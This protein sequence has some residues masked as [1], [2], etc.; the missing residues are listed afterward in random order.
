VTA[1]DAP[2]SWRAIDFLSDVH[3]HADMPRTFDAWSRHLRATDADAVFILGDLFEVWV[4]DDARAEG[5]EARCVE[6]LTQAAAHRTLAFMPGNRDFLVGD[7]LLREARVQRL[8]DPTRLDAFGQRLLLTHGDALCLADDEYQRFRA[9]VRG[10]DWQRD[11]LAKPLAERRALA[12]AMRDASA[13]RQ[14]GMGA[15]EAPNWADV[16]EAAALAWLQAADAPTLLH[17]HTHRPA[18][19]MLPEGRQ[20]V[21]LSDW[22]LDF[23]RPPRAAVLRLSAAGLQPVALAS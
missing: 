6:V 14:A 9:L 20:R 17:G 19:H 22:D 23:A 4:G 12:R 16:D 18:T 5:F 11:F 3:L 8:A 15:A 2:L 1:Y 7:T 13:Q 10:A 21:V